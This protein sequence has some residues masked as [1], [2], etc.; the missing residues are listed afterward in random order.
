MGGP[1]HQYRS[2]ADLLKKDL[3][4]VVDEKLT[5][6]QCDIVAK[7]ASGLLGCI[8]KNVTSK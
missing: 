7:K 8:K 2:G 6:S 1:L 5:M 3:G 4:V